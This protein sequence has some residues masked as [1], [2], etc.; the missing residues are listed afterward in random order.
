M[1]LIGDRSGVWKGLYEYI[2]LNG[3]VIGYSDGILLGQV[4]GYELRASYGDFLRKFQIYPGWVIWKGTLSENPNGREVGASVRVFLGNVQL[5]L[6]WVIWKDI[7]SEIPDG[8]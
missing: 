7:L 1:Y 6:D 4:N 2:F 3:I 8:P 5:D